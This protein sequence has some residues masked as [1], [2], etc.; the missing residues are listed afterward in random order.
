[1][2]ECLFGGHLGEGLIDLGT[3]QKITGG[4]HS[5]AWLMETKKLFNVGQGRGFLGT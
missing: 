3:I 1:L 5:L 4:C 2:G